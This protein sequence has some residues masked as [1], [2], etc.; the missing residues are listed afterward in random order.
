MEAGGLVE[1]EFGDGQAVGISIRALRDIAVA[2]ADDAD[3]GGAIADHLQ[4]GADD[5]VQLGGIILHGDICHA[6]A[7]DD[8]DERG[9]VFLEILEGAG[10]GDSGVLVGR[11]AGWAGHRVGKIAVSLRVPGV[12]QKGK[13]AKDRSN[14]KSPSGFPIN[15]CGVSFPRFPVNRRASRFP[16]IPHWQPAPIFQLQR[17]LRAGFYRTVETT[18]PAIRR[19]FLSDFPPGGY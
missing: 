15:G 12:C 9:A 8:F 5:V 14:W 13:R 7:L 17:S 18:V 4:G 1:F 16:R 6:V 10:D 3:V 19:D 11:V 2:V